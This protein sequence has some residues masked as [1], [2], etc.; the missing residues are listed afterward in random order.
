MR[1]QISKLSPLV[2]SIMVSKKEAPPLLG[3]S[4]S[5]STLVA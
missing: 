4:K 1:Q 5:K 2:A 3:V